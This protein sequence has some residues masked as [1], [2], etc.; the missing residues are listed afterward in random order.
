M[1]ISITLLENSFRMNVSKEK[2]I[3]NAFVDRTD[4]IRH[5]RAAQMLFYGIPECGAYKENDYVQSIKRA[6]R[7]CYSDTK[8]RGRFRDIYDSFVSLFYVYLLAKSD[9][10]SKIETT[11]AGYL[12]VV[13]KNFANDKKI[14][15]E[16]EISIGL[17]DPSTSVDINKIIDSI[18]SKEDGAVKPK[19]SRPMID[20]PETEPYWAEYLVDKY[21]DSIPNENYRVAIRA[22]VLEGMPRE[23][24]AEEL[25]TTYRAVNLLVNHAMT[26]LTNVALPDIRWRS[27]KCYTQYGH[28]VKD[29]QDRAI[30]RDYFENN[31]YHHDLALAVR[32][33][34]KISIREKKE[35]EAEERRELRGQVN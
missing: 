27:R 34:I 31:I 16:I 6:V 2:S 23:E 29:E 1:I 28:L 33:L 13:A 17:S 7:L 19:S 9:R 8:Y 11:L 26:A 22:I 20:E 24:L 5:E 18:L 25:N 14:R 4:K 15:N 12:F 32:R 21:I 30:L 35:Q 10:L 3:I